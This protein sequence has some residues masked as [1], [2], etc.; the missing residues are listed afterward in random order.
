MRKRFISTTLC[1]L[2]CIP[3]VL[4]KIELPAIL[5]HQMV[6]QQQ[7]LVK[8]W[9]KA[10]PDS[11]VTVKTSWNNK[12]TVTQADADGKWLV[13]VSTPAAGG[14]YTISIA[15]KEEIV[16]ND[17]LIGEV[18]LCSGQSN[19]VLPLK[20]REG[21]PVAG[22]NDV[23]VRAKGTL[24]LR[25]FTVANQ[26]SDTPQDNTTG[27]WVKPSSEN[28]EKVSAVAYFYGQLLQEVLDVPI[29]LI[30]S[31]SSGSK[32]ELWLPNQ[33]PCRLYNAMIHPLRNYTLKGFLWYQGESN[34]VNPES[35]S[36]LF[37][38]LPQ[39]FRRVWDL[40]ELPFYYVQI[41]PY[42]Y[43]GLESTAAAR[44]RE[45]QLQN[46]RL[47]PNAGMAVTLDLGEE[48][49]NHPAGK[50]EVG[51][52][53][54]YWALAKTYGRKG[55]GY[56]SPAYKSIEVK[57]HE[58]I[59]SFHYS[60]SRCIGPVYGDLEGFEIAASDSV[61]Y[62]AKA[63]IDIKSRQVIVSAENVPNPIAVRYAFKNYTKASL[64]DDYGLPVS[65]FRSDNW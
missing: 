49:C 40:G 27:T 11:R 29:G 53:L 23:L 38:Q 19:M 59:V 2:L 57:D 8:L 25:V 20:G 24:P 48:T 50:K 39:E 62:P 55:F 56:Q 46:E 37:P 3:V 17:I 35:Y 41:A 44:V 6:L 18:W 58:I 36:H 31:A 4:A 12:T 32:I 30:V 5:S 52:R 51:H 34:C 15:D 7:S 33:I 42:M 14:P 22:A 26:M 63:R 43:S 45:V 65:S 28:L 60:S 16:L 64:F 47:I 54:A 9:G 21:Q 61:F 10:D 13:T 1:F